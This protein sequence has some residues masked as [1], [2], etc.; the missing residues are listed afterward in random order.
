MAAA[1]ACIPS[2][3]I[4]Q[5]ASDAE[6]VGTLEAAVERR[7]RQRAIGTLLER[8][9][10]SP[11]LTPELAERL[12]RAVTTDEELATYY[13]DAVLQALDPE[14][15]GSAGT[16]T[17]L[18]EGLASNGI[19]P[20]PGRG[21]NALSV[22]AEAQRHRALPTAA[23]DALLAALDNRAVSNRHIAIGAIGATPVTDARYES[24]VAAITAVLGAN[25]HWSTRISAAKELGAMGARQALPGETLAALKSSA[26]AD[27]WMTVRMTA[28]E[29][30]A[31][32]SLAQAERDA[33]ARSL[34]A[35]LVE[36]DAERWRRSR[37][38]REHQT[39][40]HRAER[41]LDDWY[42]AP[43][44]EFV[45][46]GFVAL[47]KEHDAERSR[48]ILA[49]VRGD[50]GLN[51]PQRERLLLQAAAHNNPRIR[52]ALY[53]LLAEVRH[54]DDVE[55]ALES[56]MQGD[57]NALRATYGLLTWYEARP[58]PQRVADIATGALLASDDRELR[59]A[60][61]RLSIRGPAEIDRREA[62]LIDAAR[63]LGQNAADIEAALIELRGDAAIE[64]LVARYAADTSLHASFR[65]L[66]I[67]RLEIQDDSVLPLDA[68][69]IAALERAGRDAEDYRLL[70]SIAS[71][72]ED[73]GM[74]LPFG[75]YVKLKDTHYR[76]LG[77]AWIGCAIVTSGAGLLSLFRMASG[78][79]RQRLSGRK[80]GV[81]FLIWLLLTLIVLGAAG[82]GVI[83]AL[84][85][86][87]SP[88]PAQILLFNI[89][90]YVGTL[91]YGLFA[92]L[93]FRVTRDGS[94]PFDASGTA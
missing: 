33:L 3:G 7:D 6:L 11:P 27:P 64:R 50:G 86:N 41:L 49:S 65:S 14:L 91:V 36:P 93:L 40:R 57:E 18:A 15:R 58:M 69:T 76:A 72:Y 47:S 73:R 88:P 94:A 85:H 77:I 82:L 51:P 34:I 43:Y 23:F 25:E 12:L 29:S 32:Q 83:S 71:V 17:V 80:L 1:F 81:A 56:V 59:A 66:L 31:P 4:A 24:V 90:F 54:E 35:E 48:S 8:L 74:S 78:A 89:P 21:A 87:Y 28:L 9:Q 55:L 84:G 75:L 62:T 16:L 30:L 20:M 68:N 92:V 22:L 13:V 61:A 26:T 63:R 38:T 46:D 5:P 10:E 52:A 70:A 67:R 44:P 60:A 37:G 45:V 53:A 39:V 2:S 79:L 42:S 19:Y